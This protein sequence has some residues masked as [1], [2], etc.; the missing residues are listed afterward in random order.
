MDSGRRDKT[1]MNKCS[2]VIEF[3]FALF[4][5]AKVPTEAVQLAVNIVYRAE[6]T[7]DKE[8]IRGAK[9][10]EK[11]LRSCRKINK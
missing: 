10:L 2:F 11:W 3:L 8:L 7:D 9:A 5:Y 1:K 6:L 4:G